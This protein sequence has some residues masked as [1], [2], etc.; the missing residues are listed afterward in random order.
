MN[1]TAS[2]SRSLLFDP[3]PQQMEK[4][5]SLRTFRG[6]M[7]VIQ[8]SR[9]KLVVLEN[10]ENIATK[11]QGRQA[12]QMQ[13]SN[14]GVVLN[15]LVAFGCAA[16][17]FRCDSTQHG[18]PQKRVRMY[19]VGI[20]YDPSVAVQEIGPQDRAAVR[21][22]KKIFR[23]LS[24]IVSLLWTTFSIQTMTELKT[25]CK[26]GRLRKPG[27]KREKYTTATGK[28]KRPNG[29]A[30]TCPW[31]SRWVLY[32]RS[33]VRKFCETLHGLPRSPTGSRQCPSTDAGGELGDQAQ[34]LLRE[35]LP[36]PTR[37]RSQR[38]SM[39][40]NTAGAAHH[41]VHVGMAFDDLA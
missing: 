15:G 34:H 3:R 13:Q 36:A 4:S 29:P 16:D 31:L 37:P 41:P 5:C 24:C 22:C 8:L 23:R 11:P 26:I 14:V 17:V 10:V 7:D 18:L 6:V 1:P 40:W 39:Y 21:R 2:A 33:T 19:F 28:R 32:G 20:N 25:N 9:P 12:E 30:L 35:G 38:E 27:S